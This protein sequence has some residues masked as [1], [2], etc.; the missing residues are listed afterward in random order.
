[1]GADVG[2][3]GLDLGDAMRIGCRL[4]LGQ[5]RVALRIG[6]EHD[7]DQAFGTI[8]RFLREPPDA[9]ARGQREL[10]VIDRHI[11]RNGAKECRL[12]DAVAPDQANPRAVWNARGGAFQ[13]QLAGDPQCHV[14]D[15]EHARYLADPTARRNHPLSL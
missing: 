10:A 8:R 1:M 11:A 3:P 5:Q 9:G 7:L 14:I 15:H 2:K 6:L 12:A 4:G 13:Q